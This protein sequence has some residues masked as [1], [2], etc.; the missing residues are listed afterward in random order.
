M[1]FSGFFAINLLVSKPAPRRIM[2]QLRNN[3]NKTGTLSPRKRYP[4][5]QRRQE[6]IDEAKLFVSFYLKNKQQQ[7][8]VQSVPPLETRVPVVTFK[9]EEPNI[10][11]V[12]QM[13]TTTIIFNEAH[14]EEISHHT[15]EIYDATLKVY[16]RDIANGKVIQNPSGYF[17]AIF[18]GIVSKQQQ[19]KTGTSKPTF[20]QAAQPKAEEYDPEA[21]DIILN[22]RITR[23]NAKAIEMNIP[24]AEYRTAGEKVLIFRGYEL[25]PVSEERKKRADMLKE[26]PAGDFQGVA[27]MLADKFTAWKTEPIKQAKKFDMNGLDTLQDVFFKLKNDAFPKPEQHNAHNTD[28]SYASNEPELGA[29]ELAIDFDDQSDIQWM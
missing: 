18:R 28:N 4:N 27:K 15:Q 1:C 26:L 22:D 8:S 25:P 11:R 21:R 2:T 20:K 24:D 10:E 17:M 16:N 9:K 12:N 6:G 7:P 3:Y 5:G 19:P 14:L 23:I 13:T 29:D